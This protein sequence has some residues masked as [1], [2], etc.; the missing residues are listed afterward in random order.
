MPLERMKTVSSKSL[1]EVEGQGRPGLLPRAGPAAGFSTR[2]AELPRGRDV[3]C[4]G[5]A[6]AT[7]VTELVTEPREVGS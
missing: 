5:G 4:K 1:E 3:G 7:L 2:R 6:Q